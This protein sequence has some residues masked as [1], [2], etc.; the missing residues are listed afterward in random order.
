MSTLFMHHDQ[1]LPLAS[2]DDPRGLSV[3]KKLRP[4]LRV[5]FDNDELYDGPDFPQLL[6][7]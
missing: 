3:R 5:K 6:D 2:I 7:G 4:F 1:D